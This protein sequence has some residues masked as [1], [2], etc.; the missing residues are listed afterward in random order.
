MD[1]TPRQLVHLLF[2]LGIAAAIAFIDRPTMLAIMVISLFFGF[3]LSDALSRGHHIEGVSPLVEA[4][5]RQ[6]VL[7]G[8]GALLFVF[9]A[10]VCLF[11]FEPKVVIPAII[12]LSVLD[13]VATLAGLRYGRHRIFNGKSWE[14]AGAG[15]AAAFLALLV[16][17]PPAPAFAAAVLA[18]VIELVAPVDDN[19]LIPPCICLL[20]TVFS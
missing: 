16:I 15:I 2:G 8:K 18:G 1:E 13:G 11:F 6:N 14:G 9:S 19:L 4:L 12:A 10:L 20:L 7:P 3:L 5:E 17:L